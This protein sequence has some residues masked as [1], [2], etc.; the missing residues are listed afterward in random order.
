M[1]RAALKS[2]WAT[3]AGSTEAPVVFLW[4]EDA[5]YQQVLLLC[6]GHFSV[7]GVVEEP[8]GMQRSLERKFL[9]ATGDHAPVEDVVH[10]C[11]ARSPISSM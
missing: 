3:L 5:T 1:P 8:A 4:N 9:H 7:I 2:F 6:K 11:L 10:V